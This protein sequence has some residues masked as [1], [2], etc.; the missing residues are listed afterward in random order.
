MDS[1]RKKSEEIKSQIRSLVKQTLQEALEG[2]LE[3]YLGYPK[4][5][6]PKNKTTK[7]TNTRNGYSTK[8]VRSDSGELELEVRF[9]GLSL[10]TANSHRLRG[11]LCLGAHHVLPGRQA[12]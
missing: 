12:S 10:C 4:N 1:K 6:P 2:E 5:K 7:G 3:E 11:P 9:H 8:T